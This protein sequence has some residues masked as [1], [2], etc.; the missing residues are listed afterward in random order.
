LNTGGIVR[1]KNLLWLILLASLWGPSFV[2]IKIAVQEIPPLTMVVGRVGAAAIILLI[3]LRLQGRRLPPF[4]PIWKHIGVVAFVHNALPFTLFNWGEQY[5]DSALAAILNGTTPLFTIVLAHLFIADDRLSRRKAMGILVG[6]GGILMLIGP[7]I[8]N[9]VQA[10][11]WGLLAVTIAAVSYGVA[12]VY[13]RLH[14]RGLP[15]LVAPAAQ[16][17]LAALYLLPLSLVFEQPLNAGMPS[18]NAIAALLVLAV[19]GTALAFVV[20]YRLLERTSATYVSTVTYLIPIFGVVLGV[21]VLNEQLHW[22]A[23]LGCALI[24]GGVTMVNRRAG[25]TDAGSINPTKVHLVT[26]QPN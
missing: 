7:S 25:Q 18:W 2:F 5:I 3:I 23:Y 15:P 13:T 8:L 22:T 24:L 17:A 19:F 20:Y 1:V 26:S 14:L 21:L 9:G 4:G 11:T 6:F 16:L 10:T 12:I